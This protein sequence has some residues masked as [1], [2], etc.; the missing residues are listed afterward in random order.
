VVISSQRLVCECLTCVPHLPS[1]INRIPS[2]VRS[3]VASYWPM[4][5]TRLYFRSHGSHSNGRLF[6]RS[7]TLKRV[8]RTPFLPS[9]PETTYL[10]ESPPRL[11]LARCPPSGL[12]GYP[13]CAPVRVRFSTKHAGREPRFFRSPVFEIAL[14]CAR[15]SRSQ[16]VF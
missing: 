15:H 13:A 2:Q 10:S 9:M 12:V 16:P 7:C 14:F 6:T 8:G 3:H 4:L 11:A 5:F 1:E